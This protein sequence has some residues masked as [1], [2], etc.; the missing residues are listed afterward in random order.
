MDEREKIICLWFDM[1]L[2]QQELGVDNIFF[3][4]M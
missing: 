1:W 4:M 2:A 3:Q